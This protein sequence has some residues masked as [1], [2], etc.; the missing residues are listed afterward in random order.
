MYQRRPEGVHSAPSPPRESSP[1]RDSPPPRPTYSRIGALWNDDFASQSN[2]EKPVNEIHVASKEQSRN[3]IT[4]TP[5][6]SGPSDSTGHRPV[7]YNHHHH[8]SRNL[9]PPPPSSIYQSA[10]QQ[11]APYNNSNVSGGE[12]MD[13][14]IYLR[15]PPLT[16]QS[17]YPQHPNTLPPLSPISHRLYPSAPS[18]PP[19]LTRPQRPNTV[20]PL[21]H[22][23]QFDLSGKV[24][25][26]KQ[27]SWGSYSDIWC[28]TLLIGKK[29]VGDINLKCHVGMPR[30]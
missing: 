19:P 17:A 21:S 30:L 23:S 12:R 10:S 24:G 11:Q 8:S 27:V 3:P 20:S 7:I 2:L 1:S 14:A 29:T 16:G 25:R 26:G 9:G 6:D 13:N 4:S 22:I 5:T 28:G 15:V 18:F